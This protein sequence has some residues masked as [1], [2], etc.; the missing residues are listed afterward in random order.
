[1]N[2]KSI[3]SEASK[4]LIRNQYGVYDPDMQKKYDELNP[5]WAPVFFMNKETDYFVSQTGIVFNSK[6]NKYLT[7][8]VGTTGYFVVALLVDN[9]HYTAKVHRLVA[10]AF[11]YNDDP[12]HNIFVDHVNG[13]KLDNYYKNLEWVTPKENINRAMKLGLCNDSPIWKHGQDRPNVKYSDATIRKVCELLEQGYGPKE[14]AA[15][16]NINPN[17]PS[18]IKYSGRWRHISKDYNFPRG[19]PKGKNARHIESSEK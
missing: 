18:C 15:H 19:L 12:E 10:K 7:Q 8:Y 16:L 3:S 13:N 4:K 17:V 14:I 11:C 5:V 1:M 9:K 2:P 6:T